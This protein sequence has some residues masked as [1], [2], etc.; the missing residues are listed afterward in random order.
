MTKMFKAGD[1]V[2]TGDISGK[3]ER[4]RA[5]SPSKVTVMALVVKNEDKHSFQLPDGTKFRVPVDNKAM[6][7]V[8]EAEWQAGERKPQPQ[9]QPEPQSLPELMDHLKWLL[10]VGRMWKR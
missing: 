2:Y 5:V 7:C 4:N 10:Q 1:R 8:A 6:L 3:V 9:P